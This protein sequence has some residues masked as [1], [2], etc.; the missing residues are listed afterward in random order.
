MDSNQQLNYRGAA[1]RPTAVL[2]SIALV[3]SAIADG[4]LIGQAAIERLSPQ[5]PSMSTTTLILVVSGLITA[6]AGTIL[7]VVAIRRRH[8]MRIAV[9]SVILAQ[10]QYVYDRFGRA[11]GTVGS[12]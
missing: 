6:L 5:W 11:I 2:A 10:R 3:L 8:A 9:A 1:K 12:P 4:C 7:G